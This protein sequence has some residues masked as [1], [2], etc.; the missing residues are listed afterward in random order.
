MHLGLNCQ[1]DFED[2]LREVHVTINPG[3]NFRFALYGSIHFRSFCCVFG[4]ACTHCQTD[5]EGIL[6]SVFVWCSPLSKFFFGFVSKFFFAA[7]I[8]AEV[9][10]QCSKTA[11]ATSRHVFFF[12]HR[13]AGTGFSR[14]QRFLRDGY[15]AEKSALASAIWVK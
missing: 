15:W 5:F 7:S 2:I 9:Q 8:M 12:C 14:L 1:V 4:A 10:M 11:M 6:D 3:Q 13:V